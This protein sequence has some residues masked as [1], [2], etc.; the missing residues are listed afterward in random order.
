MLSIN[1][2]DSPAHSSILFVGSVNA[3]GAG[4]GGSVSSRALSNSAYSNVLL[5]TNTS[6]GGGDAVTLS[7][8]QQPIP[9]L[10][11]MVAYT[12]TKAT[13]V[14]PLTS[15]VSNSNF[16]ARSIFNPN[17]EVAANSAYTVRDRFSGAINWSRAFIGKYKTTMG[18]FYEGR[19]G[20]PYSW[21]YYNDLNGDGL[22][23]NDLMYIPKAPGSGEVVFAGGAAEEARFWEIVNSTPELEGAKG[24]VVGRNGSSSPWVTSVDV[25][26]SQEVPGFTSRHKG[27]ISFD[28]LNFGNL[29]NKRWGRVDEVAFQSAGG[30]ARSFVNYKGL[31]AQ[32]RY[33][34]SLG[35][36]ED[37]TTRQAKGESQWA[38]QI[39]A[40][41]EF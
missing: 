25:R 16:N 30:A 20:K 12:M 28:I 11:W 38:V 1:H 22:A 5:A 2:A 32:G 13:E 27:V 37:Y 15:S 33:V 35:S 29:L 40:R 26:L 4:C 8:S 9:G 19:R 41:Y 18:V 14:S 10:N 21:T 3:T 24:K 17:E 39:T 31:D 34:Y 23:G 7:L 6:K 36:V